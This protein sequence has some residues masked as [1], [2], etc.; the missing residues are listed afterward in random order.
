[1]RRCRTLAFNQAFVHESKVISGRTVTEAMHDTHTLSSSSVSTLPSTHL[2][3]YQQSVESSSAQAPLSLTDSFG[4]VHNYLRVSL[5]ER[6]NLRCQYC[7][8]EEGI[9]LTEKEE[10]LSAKEFGRLI[11]VF[12]S[13]GVDKIRLTGGEPLVYPEIMDICHDIATIGKIKKLAITTNGILLPRKM[14]ALKDAGVS[15][16]NIS[17]DTL[18]PHRYM[19]LARANGL[20]KV[21]ESIRMSEEMGFDSVKI[22]CVVMRG[23]NDDEIV[24][25]VKMT[26][27]RQL[28]VRFIEYMPFDQNKWERRKMVSFMEMMDIIERGLSAD[29]PPQRASD[30]E[31]SNCQLDKLPRRKRVLYDRKKL[32]DIVGMS[33]LL[34]P[35]LRPKRLIPSGE[36]EETAKLFKVADYCGRIGFITSMTTN[37][38]QT[39]NRLRLT[40]DGNLKV[41]LFGNDEVSLRDPMRAG[42]T[43]S[44]LVTL[45]QEALNKKYKEHGGMGSPEEIA[46]SQNRSMIRIGG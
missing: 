46:T 22:N 30:D 23:V 36:R 35:A 32:G 7:M 20:D 18:D 14:K 40:A 12:A 15:A 8:P 28:E 38:C 10:L 26:K 19:L 39:C 11:K 31:Q 5:T 16:L 4:R 9:K 21:L 24:D 29:D 37:F 17:L 43:D 13:V 3:T 41:C 34:S 33:H 2:G 1:M 44:E 6:C 42:A 45:I 25:F 27:H